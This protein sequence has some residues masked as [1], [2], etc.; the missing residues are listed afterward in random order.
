MFCPCLKAGGLRL[1]LAAGFA[2]NTRGRQTSAILAAGN[3][4]NGRKSVLCAP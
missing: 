1:L 4:S 2:R 3:H